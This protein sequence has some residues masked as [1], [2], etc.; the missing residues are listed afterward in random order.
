[1]LNDAPLFAASAEA[2]QDSLLT[3]SNP[4]LLRKQYKK[5]QINLFF[6]VLLAWRDCFRTWVANNK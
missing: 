3:C 4:S 6:F 1:M 2:A 5:E